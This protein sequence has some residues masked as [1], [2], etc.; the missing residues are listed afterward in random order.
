MAVAS[1][2]T[3][4]GRHEQAAGAAVELARLAEEVLRRRRRHDL[5]GR[6]S[7]CLL[8]LPL[9]PLQ[10]DEARVPVGL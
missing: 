6:A 5:Q 10:E 4:E 3:I 8:L 7:S 9:A 2:G 1:A